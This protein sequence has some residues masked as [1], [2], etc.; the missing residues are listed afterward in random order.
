MFRTSSWC[1]IRWNSGQN[2]RCIIVIKNSKVRMSRNL[3][4]S[5]EAQMEKSWSSMEDSVVLLERNL[6]GH[7]QAGLLWERQFGKVLVEHGWENFFKL[8]IFT[9]H[10]SKRTIPISICGRYQI[11]RKK[12]N[13][14]PTWK[15]LMEDVDL[16]E[17]TSF[18]DHEKLGCTPRECKISDEI[19]ANYREMFGISTGAKDKLPIRASEKPDTEPKSSWSY[20]V[21]GRAKK[22]VERYC[23]LANKTTQHSHKVATPCMIDHQFKE[24]ENESVGKLSKV[25]SHIVL[26]CLNL[27]RIVRP[28]FS[29]VCE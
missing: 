13:I 12:E 29:E 11:G 28:D 6:Y 27:A 24:E 9:C 19:V 17:P 25:C 23:E 15:I 1:S 22:C 16:V 10:P 20:D 7:P 21:E 2:G 5:T 8:G 4:T 14:E 3:D 26:K 18:L